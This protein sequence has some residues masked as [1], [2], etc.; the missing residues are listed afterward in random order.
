MPY[1]HHSF[2]TE[3]EVEKNSDETPKEELLKHMEKVDKEIAEVE[4]QILD[5]K[6]K[7]VNKMKPKQKWPL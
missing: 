4:K 3:N 6:E 1:N 5:L 7:K 2:A